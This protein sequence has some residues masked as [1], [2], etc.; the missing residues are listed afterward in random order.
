MW[1]HTEESQK[2]ITPDIALEF[3][4]D[5]NKRFLNNL[6]I[7]RNLLK[8]VN[9]TSDGQFP[10]ATI[11]SCIDSRTSAEFIFD[12]G[13]GDIFSIRIA[14]NILNED[15]LGSLEYACKIANSKLIVV[16]GHTRC[17][18]VMSAVDNF[19]MG[20]FTGLVA[21][22]KPAI[23]V[24]KEII[25]ERNGQNYAFVTNVSINNIKHTIQQIRK[26]S[27]ILRDLENRKEIGIAGGLYDVETGEV[28]FF[29]QHE[30]I[31]RV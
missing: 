2:K 14:G 28:R 31:T 25:T 13:L 9:Q 27:K 6:K 18:A 30:S 11:L 4:K 16:L 3:L 10:F 1:T 7:N 19:K 15:I 24:E 8:Q 12:Q 21:K 5:G 17:A 26:K 29:E 20:Y 22:L 23:E